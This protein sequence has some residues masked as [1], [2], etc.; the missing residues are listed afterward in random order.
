MR[1]NP[2]QFAVVREDPLVEASL[3]WDMPQAK[4]VLLIASGGCTALSLQSLLP[5]MKFTLLDV[6]PSQLELIQKKFSHL[7]STKGAQ[8]KSDFNIE[9]SRTSGLNACGN[10]ESLFRG[11]REFIFE[12]VVP[13]GEMRHLFE[14]ENI[15]EASKERIFSNKYWPVG[16][17]MYFCD[18]FL[19]AM[20][21][22]KAIQHAPKGSYPKHFKSV[23]EGGFQR[24]DARTNYFLHHIFLGHYLA[25]DAALPEVFSVQ[26]SRRRPSKFGRRTPDL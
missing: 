11:L 21:T 10:F 12:F 24:T 17:E 7:H 23:L 5:Q 16:F 1:N 18:D 4:E 8:F 3:L 19:R 2:I 14:E 15:A 9:D 25:N 13:Y 20:F 22:E 26:I 6:N